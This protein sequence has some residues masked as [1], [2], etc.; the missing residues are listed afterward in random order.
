MKTI[1][2]SLKEPDIKKKLN[3]FKSDT[4]VTQFLQQ[5][6]YLLINKAK[7]ILSIMLS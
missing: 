1:S 3:Q 4:K 6:K 2:A 7:K 5:K